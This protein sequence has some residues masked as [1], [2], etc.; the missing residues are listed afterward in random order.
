M[1]TKPNL[2]NVKQF[3][4]IWDQMEYLENQSLSSVE[5][6]EWQAIFLWFLL[7][8]AISTFMGSIHKSNMSE[9]Y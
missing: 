3:L 2:N 4:Q 5:S 6:D 7:Y 1:P 9:N 8:N